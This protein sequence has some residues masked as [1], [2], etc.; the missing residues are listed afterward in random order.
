MNARLLTYLSILRISR[1][2]GFLITPRS[3]MNAVT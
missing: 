3:V 2:K 1:V